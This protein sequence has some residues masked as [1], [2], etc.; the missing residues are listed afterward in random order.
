MGIYE[1]I[2]GTRTDCSGDGRAGNQGAYQQRRSKVYIG[3]D[4]TAIRCTLATLWRF[5]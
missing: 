5:A 4:P 1:E 3:F 2:T